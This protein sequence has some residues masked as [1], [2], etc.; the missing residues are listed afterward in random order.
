M[1]ISGNIAKIYIEKSRAF[2]IDDIHD[3]ELVRLIA[4][5]KICLK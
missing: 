2:D 3:L 4:G 1:R 5:E